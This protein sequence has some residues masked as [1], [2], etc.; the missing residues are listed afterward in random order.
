MSAKQ[1]I[2][3]NPGDTR[4]SETYK[5]RGRI[6]NV[7]LSYDLTELLIAELSGKYDEVKSPKKLDDKDKIVS[8]PP[9]QT[10]RSRL[11]AIIKNANVDGVRQI[12]R[13]EGGLT[14]V[15]EAM[16]KLG[17]QIIPEP[18]R[19]AILRT[20]EEMRHKMALNNPLNNNIRFDKGREK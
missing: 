12:M 19:E 13:Q 1:E 3:Q 8:A 7:F 16:K 14:M 20:L 10:G 6:R 15:K 9:E 18:E 17:I 5:I 11:E 2:R 4:P